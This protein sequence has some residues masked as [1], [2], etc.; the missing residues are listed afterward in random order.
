MQFDNTNALRDD[1]LTGHIW[2]ITPDFYTATFTAP[3]SAT[4]EMN[5]MSA[6]NDILEVYRNCVNHERVSRM[7]KDEYGFL[8]RKCIYKCFGGWGL[9]NQDLRDTG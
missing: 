6:F 1:E 8:W 7:D 9:Y 4:F 2:T 3:E 5:T